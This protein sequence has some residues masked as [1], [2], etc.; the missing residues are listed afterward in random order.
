M[1][2]TFR[3]LVVII[4]SCIL[5]LNMSS[6]AFA[7][8]QDPFEKVLEEYNKKYNIE[9][10]YV[11][12][13]EYAD[14]SEYT[15]FVESVAKENRKTLNYIQEIKARESV[16]KR[17]E[18]SEMRATII[19]KEKSKTV[20]AYS[21]LGED[22]AKPY[23]GTAT[24]HIAKG[25]VITDLVR[26]SAKYENSFMEALFPKT[27]EVT[28]YTS[29]LYDSGHTLGVTARGKLVGY[30]KNYQPY[31]LGNVTTMYMYSDTY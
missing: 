9:L 30:D 15:K 3:I 27:Y 26:F 10:E 23:K 17:Q 18:I 28:S 5:C 4:V 12:V 20:E 16:L 14:L 29:N 2:K 25:N 11:P 7:T 31:E 21:A 8:V 19:V 6:M 13:G 22:T 24:Y 1:K